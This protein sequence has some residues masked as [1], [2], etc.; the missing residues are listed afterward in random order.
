MWA[1]LGLTASESD[2][3]AFSIYLD[4]ALPQ[5]DGFED[6]FETEVWLVDMQQRLTPLLPDAQEQRTLLIQI[7]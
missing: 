4:R 7:R 6:R 1:A 5:D 3:A 2:R